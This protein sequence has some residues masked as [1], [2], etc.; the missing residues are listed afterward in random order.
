MK[1]IEDWFFQQKLV[2][3]RAGI[4]RIVCGFIVLVLLILGP[5]D[6]FLIGLQSLDPL[7]GSIFEFFF[8]YY[9]PLKWLTIGAAFF[10]MLGFLTPLSIILTFGGFF[11]NCYLNYKLTPYNWGYTPHIHIFLL[12]LLF[13]QSNRRWSLDAFFW[14]KSSKPVSESS[15]FALSFLMIYVGT[16]YFQSG[17]AKLFI[18]GLGWLK[19]GMTIYQFSHYFGTDLGHWLMQYPFLFTVFAV[20]T[21]VFELLFIFFIFNRRGLLIAFSVSTLFHLGVG[22]IMTLSFWHLVLLNIPLFLLPGLKA[23]KSR[24]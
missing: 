4:L 11:L 5:S 8:N 23:L 20:Y 3:Q 12:A 16:I 2:E 10:L 13:C 7:N 22:A 15:S 17:V 19:S 24:S 1:K 18:G 14:P 6:D 21:V 9:S